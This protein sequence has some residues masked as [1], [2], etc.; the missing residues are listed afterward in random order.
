MSLRRSASDDALASAAPTSSRAP[1]TS[2]RPL[3][4]TPTASEISAVSVGL[5]LPPFWSADPHIWFAQVEAQFACRRITSQKSK[6]DHV[7][8]SLSPEFAVE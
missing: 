7:V 2:A 5:K 8:A 4:A 3:A 1:S 6:F